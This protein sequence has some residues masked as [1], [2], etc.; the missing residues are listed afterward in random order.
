MIELCSINYFSGLGAGGRGFSRHHLFVAARVRAAGSFASTRS[1][2][3]SGLQPPAP[4]PYLGS[5]LP[6]PK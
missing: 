5:G 2:T 6:D 4:S 1:G 3:F